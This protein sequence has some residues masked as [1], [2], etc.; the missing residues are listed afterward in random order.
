VGAVAAADLDGVGRPEIVLVDTSR[1]QLVVLGQGADDGRISRRGTVDLGGLAVEGVLPADVDADG[2]A[3]LL[4]WN[5]TRFATVQVGGQDPVL[6]EGHTYESPVK[7]AYLD[8]LAVGDVNGDGQ[9]ELV[10]T[11][12]RKHLMHIAAVKPDGLHHALKFPVYEARM[13]ESSRR[14]SR[15]PREVLVA[16]LTGDGLED[17]AILVHDRLIVYPQEPAR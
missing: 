12:T 16:D 15:E 9:V 3:D 10:F 13:F 1:D 2:R 17:I 7:D 4:L 11:E 8:R 6:V 14:S 5:G